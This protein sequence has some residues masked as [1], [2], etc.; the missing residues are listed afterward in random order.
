MWL[1]EK[2]TP[3]FEVRLRLKKRLY[4]A[5]SSYQRIEVVETFDFG[6]V[7]LLDGLIQLSTKD[8][9]LYHGAL[10]DRGF[11]FA[12]HAR[13]VL[14]IGGGDGGLLTA[15]LRRSEVELVRL[16]EIDEEVIACSKRFFPQLARGFKDPRAEIVIED[17]AAYVRRAQGEQFDLIMVDAPD[18]VGEGAK[19]FA[20]TF[21]RNCAQLLA[22]KGVLAAQ[23]ESPYFYPQISRRVRRAFTRIFPRV[24]QETVIVP[25]YPGGSIGFTFGLGR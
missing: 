24:E 7:L 10:A 8:Q 19:L 4:R 21:Y 11:A 25:S 12:P 6:R 13:R 1:T 14:I 20:A 3:T 17:G 22:P 23:S 9:H 15:V 18:P 2:V 16:V 5:R